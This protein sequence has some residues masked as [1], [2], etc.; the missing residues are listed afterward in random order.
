[1]YG[2]MRYADG[3]FGVGVRVQLYR[4]DHIRGRSA[5][6]LAASTV[7]N[8]RGEYRI[9]GLSPGGYLVAAEYDPPPR[10]TIANSP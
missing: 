6:T 3:E 7:A 9:Y 1:M 8:D 2:R 4:T 10:P 5:Y